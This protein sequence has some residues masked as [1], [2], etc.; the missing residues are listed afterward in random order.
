MRRRN[1]AGRRPTPPRSIS[2]SGVPSP[3]VDAWRPTVVGILLRASRD[4]WHESCL[5]MIFNFIFAVSALPGFLLLSYAFSIRQL[6]L[7]ALGLLALAA[8]PFTTF[9]LFYAAA[10][11][12]SGAPIHFRTFI[13]GGRTRIGL[14]Y[15]WGV[16]SLVVMGVLVVNAFFYLDSQAPLFG[17]WIASFLGALFLLASVAWLISQSWLLAI[18]ATLDLASLRAGWAE[19]RWVVQ[20]RPGAVLGLGLVC[21]GLLAAGTVVVPLGLLLAF[22]CAAVLACRATSD[23]RLG[24]PPEAARKGA[25]G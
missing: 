17:T 3:P 24:K 12:V 22:A 5:L 16:L 13:D 14:A 25:D 19:L 9:G 10:R 23:I 8:W 2:T 1:E 21:V 15:R 18:L 4:L 11:A 7:G 20:R 6:G